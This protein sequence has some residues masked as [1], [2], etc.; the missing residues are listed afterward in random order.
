MCFESTDITKYKAEQ[1]IVCYKIMNSVYDDFCISGHVKTKYYFGK[2]Y[3][4]R[5]T[6]FRPFWI[7]SEYYWRSFI[8]FRLFNK[9]IGKHRESMFD[10]NIKTINIHTG[11]HSYVDRN[12]DCSRYV[13]CI[14]PK[15]ATYYRSAWEYVS[16]K[17]IIVGEC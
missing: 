5:N 14:I 3:T 17:I 7:Y 9:I 10:H 13:K 15:G 16:N 2:L 8:L 11:F 6:I 1:D 4:L 12:Y